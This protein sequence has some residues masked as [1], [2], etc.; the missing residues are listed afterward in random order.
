MSRYAALVALKE[1]RALEIDRY[2]DEYRWTID[3]AR[4]PDDHVYSNKAPG[5]VFVAYPLFWVWD[6]LTTWGLETREQRDQRRFY[7]RHAALFGLSFLFQ[8]FPMILLVLLWEERLRRKGF[9]RTAIQVFAVGA[10]FAQTSAIFMNTFF[11]HGVSAWLALLAF[12]FASDMGRHRNSIYLG[13]TLGW[14]IACDYTA[15]LLVPGAF[16]LAWSQLDPE[17]RSWDSMKSRVAGLGLGL[18]VPLSLL[19]NYQ[20]KAFGSSWT[21]PQRYQNP[22]F[23]D[24]TDPDNQ[25]WGI[26]SLPKWSSAIELL[27][28]PSRGIL[29]TQPWVF[30]VI[31]LIILA[32]RRG[33][34]WRLGSTFPQQVLLTFGLFLIMNSSFGAWHAG[35]SAGPRYLSQALILFALLLPDLWEQAQLLTKRLLLVGLGVG[36]LLLLV[37]YSSFITAPVGQGIWSYYAEEYFRSNE[38]MVFWVRLAVC[39]LVLGWAVRSRSR[40]SSLR[41]EK[42]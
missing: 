11:G 39:L 5:P 9:S 14:A 38:S 16:I 24:L 35:S 30:I 13:L 41:I 22:A 37:A 3:W 36:V 12:Y 32:W 8:V 4:T 34:A 7:L 31:G 40:V 2:V 6:E 26:F 25:L 15:A 10:L 42:S 19:A 18:L 27:V 28:G 21:L 20:K 23:V 33:Q 1:D 29:W 17:K